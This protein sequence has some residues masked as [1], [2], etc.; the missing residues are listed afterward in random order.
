MKTRPPAT[1]ENSTWGVIQGLLLAAA[2]MFTLRFQIKGAPRLLY[3][4][5][6]LFM[7]ADETYP[8]YRDIML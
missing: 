7:K 4:A 3:A 6:R 1:E 5:R 8:A 2:Q